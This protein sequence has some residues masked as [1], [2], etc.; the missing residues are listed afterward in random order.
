MAIRNAIRAALAIGLLFCSACGPQRDD[1]QPAQPSASPLDAPTAARFA[2]VE[3][4]GTGE[5]PPAS[6]IAYHPLRQTLFIVNDDGHVGEI[7]TDG[8]LVQRRHLMFDDFEAIAVHPGSGMLYI[9]IEGRDDVLEVDP[10]GLRVRREYD[11]SR[12]FKGRKIY[13]SGG[14]GIEGLTFVPRA[15]HSEGGTFF[16]ANRSSHPKDLDDPPLLMEVEL[17]LSS[18]STGALEG[19]IVRAT[20]LTLTGI[21]GLHYLGGDRLYA[22]SDDRKLLVELTLAGEVVS[23]QELRASDPEGVTTDPDGNLY[24]AQ[25][26]GGILKL[27]LATPSGADASP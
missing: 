4:I 6:G 7:R 26:G 23:A 21:S 25:D 27:R 5:F 15:G 11:L 10:D 3:G 9:A 16:V 8:S 24:I 19:K 17:P 2:L 1:P 13:E 18:T 12:R 14:E 22:I 20:R